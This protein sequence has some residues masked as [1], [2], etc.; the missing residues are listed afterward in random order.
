MKKSIVFLLHIGFWGA[1]LLFI[2]LLLG[3][4]FKGDIP[5]S[6][7]PEFSKIIFSVGMIPAF[8]GFYGFY[9]LLFPNYL[10]HK[11]AWLTA[12]YGVLLT[13]VAIV[14]G[15]IVLYL[16]HGRAHDYTLDCFVTGI[17][18]LTLIAVFSQVS[19]LIINHTKNKR[20]MT[21]QNFKELAQ[22]IPMNVV[23]RVHKSYMVAL[24]KIESIERNRIKIGE[25]LI[26]ISETYKSGFYARINGKG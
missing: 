21:V 3:I 7:I 8:V 1:Y 25:E 9:F 17:P 2:L 5:E 12:I 6:R 13:A 20:I 19:S 10:K 18:I 26:P 14:S 23:C 15:D 22:M 24:D 11:K 16:I 4:Y